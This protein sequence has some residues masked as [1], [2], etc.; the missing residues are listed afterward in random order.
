MQDNLSYFNERVPSIEQHPLAD[1]PRSCPKST[2]SK[3][4][5][6]LLHHSALI[7]GASARQPKKSTRNRVPTIRGRSTNSR[8][9]CWWCKGT[10]KI[11]DHQRFSKKELPPVLPLRTNR[12]GISQG[13]SNYPGTASLP[14]GRST[15]CRAR[16]GKLIDKVGALS[17]T[18]PS[19]GSSLVSVGKDT[20]KNRQ[21]LYSIFFL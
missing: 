16:Q 8:L 10:K 14:S 9:K 5:C 2:G 15:N 21:K 18:L 13:S 3:K 12:G 11:W 20:K 7:A 4:H 6:L 19:N 1:S 17:T